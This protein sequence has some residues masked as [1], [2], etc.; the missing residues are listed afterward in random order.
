MIW[1]R[2]RIPDRTSLADFH[3]VIQIV[4]G[5]DDEHLHRFHIYG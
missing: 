4:F 5:W 2:L 3:H 1:C